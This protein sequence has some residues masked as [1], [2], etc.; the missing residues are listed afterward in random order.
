MKARKELGKDSMGIQKT[1]RTKDYLGDGIGQLPLNALTC[2]IAQITYFY[3]DKVGVAAASA[4]TMLVIAKVIDAFTD[5]A[6]GKIMD[7]VHSPEGRCKPWFKWMSLP[8][9]VI[10]VL[11]FTVPKSAPAGVQNAYI[12]IT[13][14]LASA[15][16][17]TAIAIPYGAIMAVRTDSAEERGK[18]GIFRSIFGYAVGMVI[19]ILLIPI[20]NMLGGDQ[21]AWIKVATV[22]AVVS[23]VGMLILYRSSKETAGKTATGNGSDDDLPFSKEMG[24]LFHNKYWVLMLFANLV[25]NISYG[26]SSASGTY[27]TKY[28]LGNDNLVALLGAV[29][30]IPTLLGFALVGPMTKKLGMAKTCQIAC[31]IGIAGG[32]YRVFT[33]Y[34]LVSCLV[35]G[36]MITFAN[37]PIMCLMGAMVNNCVEYNDWKFHH[38]MLGLSNS[39]SSFGSKIGSGIGGSLIGWILGAC[40]YISGADAASQPASV[41]GGI[42]AFAI[43]IP[44]ILLIILVILFHKYDLEKIYPKIVAELQARSTEEKKS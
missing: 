14:I 10:M 25:M 36:S 6:M 20:T 44:L 21:A 17:Y 29:G 12:L 35:G 3:T 11:L 22:F 39:A 34:S 8:I 26:L 19:A 37:I 41:T 15:V 40:G 28:I 23:F 16:I 7:K 9:A 27:Y 24:L 43:Y 18:M 32:I 42:F 2:L 33:P 30:M 4:A 5:L 31:L 1:M 38:R 13:E